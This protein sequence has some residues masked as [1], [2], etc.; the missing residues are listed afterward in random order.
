LSEVELRGV[1]DKACL[2]FSAVRLVA[3]PAFLY[4]ALTLCGAD[5]LVVGVAVLS[6]AMPAATTTAMLAQKYN[7]DAAYAAKLIFVST[8]LSLATLPAVAAILQ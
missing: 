7:G 8:V 2:Y 4:G 3:I 5:A 1:L 6:S